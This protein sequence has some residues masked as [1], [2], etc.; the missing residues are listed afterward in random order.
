MAKREY[1]KILF[2][3]GRFVGGSL[4]TGRQVE[5]NGVKVVN[6]AGDPVLEYSF[7]C[8][9]PK[10]PGVDWQAEGWGQQMLAVAQRDWPQGQWRMPTFSWK[11]TDGDSTIPNSNQKIPAER[12]GYP[13][14]WVIYFSSRYAVNTVNR[15]G[16]AAVPSDSIKPGHF[17]QVLSSAAGNDGKS[18]G[19]YLNHDA[20]AHSA[21]GPE[22]TLQTTDFSTVGFGA[23]PLPPGASAQPIGGLAVPGVPV[24][25]APAAPPTPIPTVPHTA[26]L[27]VPPPTGL[28]YV[29][30]VAAI[31][32]GA[33]TVEDV[34]AWPGWSLEIALQ[35][36]YVIAA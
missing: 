28:R 6:D 4:T 20:V 13:G 2:P 16:S 29:L 15:D 14:N 35:H 12:E 19:I 31:E 25:A 32:K 23:A 8:A 30:G 1:V 11:L 33:K 3:V 7:G 17:I 24:A 5:S 18:P 27:D 21:F 34:L 36:S 9:I 10:T 26:P 22:I